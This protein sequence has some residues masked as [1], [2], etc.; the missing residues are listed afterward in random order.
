MSKNI[1][2]YISYDGTNETSSYVQN[3]CDN[4]KKYS[5]YYR[6]PNT[7]ILIRRN[8]SSI[9]TSNIFIALVSLK[10]FDYAAAVDE[11]ECA[12]ETN[13]Q[14]F[15]LKSSKISSF[16]I[17]N[18]KERNEKTELT[19]YY[20]QIMKTLEHISLPQDSFSKK[21]PNDLMKY[22]CDKIDQ[23]IKANKS[24]VAKNDFDLTANTPTPLDIKGLRL[25]NIFDKKT[26]KDKYFIRGVATSNNQIVLIVYN[27]E[28]KAYSIYIFDSNIVLLTT[29]EA[30]ELKIVEPTLITINSK[31]TILI[32][33]NE[34]GKI[35]AF[36]FEYQ[37]SKN[38]G[39]YDTKL[40]DFNDMTVDEETDDVY[41][42]KFAST[43]SEIKVY[44][45]ETKRVKD[46]PLPRELSESDKFKPR[47][48]RVLKDRVFLVN[49]CSLRICQNTR[50][51][52]ETSSGESCIYVLDKKSGEIKL[53]INFNNYGLC[54]PWALIVDQDL[55]IYTT[56]SRIEEKKF[57]L[58]KRFLCKLNKGGDLECCEEIATTSLPN[59]IFSINGSVIIVSETDISSYLPESLRI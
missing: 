26:W 28:A 59:D 4:L 22:V 33:D 46:F 51:I 41:F 19:D 14:I 50:E 15:C 1:N 12:L 7:G 58:N 57:I 54:Q 31:S 13:R 55:N 9:S 43:N 48:V 3:L 24:E 10:Y 6:Q 36:N 2:I 11:F 23:L 35:K 34:N 47:F 30:K 38:K 29:F 5:T 18:V 42:V 45:K 16:S 52:I 20:V 40:K 27:N 8:I 17:E 49:L 44:E 39:L 25:K 21:W 53:N 37:K 56:A 32:F